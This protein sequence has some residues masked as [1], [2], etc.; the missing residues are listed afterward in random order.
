MPG[1]PV[2]GHICWFRCQ[3]H[4]N[5]YCLHIICLVKI[6]NSKLKWIHLLSGKRAWDIF[7]CDVLDSSEQVK[8]MGIEIRE[9]MVIFQ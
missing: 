7:I 9:P 2:D 4:D 6:N 5:Q 3:L 8:V 1:F